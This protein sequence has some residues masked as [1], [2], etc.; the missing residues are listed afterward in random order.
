MAGLTIVPSG[1]SA[2]AKASVQSTYT[3]KEHQRSGPMHSAEEDG[4]LS[5]QGTRYP[6]V[7]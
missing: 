5:V 7:V 4:A 6:S 3:V 2:N 1:G